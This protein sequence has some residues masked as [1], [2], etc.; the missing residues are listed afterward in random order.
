M[1]VQLLLHDHCCLLWIVSFQQLQ[2]IIEK[3]LVFY[4]GIPETCKSLQQNVRRSKRC[5]QSKKCRVS[6]SAVFGS[7]IRSQS[8][9]AS[10]YFPRS[11]STNASERRS[12]AVV[13]GSIA[14]NASTAVLMAFS[15]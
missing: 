13:A 9:S 10:A 14:S 6:P 12:L 1:F 2:L 8:G 11:E 4:P 15:E 3:F 5:A 7:A